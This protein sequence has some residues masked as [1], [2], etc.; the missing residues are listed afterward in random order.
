MGNLL[1]ILLLLF[2]SLAILVK[3]TEKRAK[4]LDA[5]QQSKLSRIIIILVLIMLVARLVQ[6]LIEG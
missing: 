3:V 6:Y 2:A 1:L 4:P 5:D